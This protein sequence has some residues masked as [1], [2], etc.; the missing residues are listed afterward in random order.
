MDLGLGDVGV[1]EDLLWDFD[2][3]VVDD[4]SDLYTLSRSWRAMRRVSGMIPL[5][6]PEW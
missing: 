4:H 2:F 3:E 5:S 6:S 1:L